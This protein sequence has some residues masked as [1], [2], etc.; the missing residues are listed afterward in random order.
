MPLPKELFPGGDVSPESIQ[1]TLLA[2]CLSHEVDT[3]SRP[4]T[5]DERQQR[6]ETMPRL[7]IQ[8]GD[9]NEQLVA[10]RDKI[11]GQMKPLAA[12]KSQLLKE[13]RTGRVEEKGETYVIP[14]DE[15]KR[16]G[17]YDGHGRLIS[18]RSMTPEERQQRFKF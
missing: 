1:E 17:I 11:K 9:L 6:L 14:F 16:V 13:V 4:L 10:N 8:L 18:E 3:Y 5:E 7:D 15:D 2:D 12:Q